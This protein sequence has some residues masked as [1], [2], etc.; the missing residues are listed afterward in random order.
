MPSFAQ[1]LRDRVHWI[2]EAGEKPEYAPDIVLVDITGRN[3]IQEGWD[4]NSKTGEFTAPI[5]PDHTSVEP[6]PTIG[7]I[8]EANL[9]ETQYQTLLIEM[10]AGF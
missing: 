3:D 4:Y 1:I 10:L 5:I 8:L 9:L 7:E 2:F 6:Q